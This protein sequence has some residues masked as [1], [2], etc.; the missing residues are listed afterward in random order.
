MPL[1]D[2]LLKILG[3][4]RQADLNQSAIDL[5][6]SINQSQ[7]NQ[8][9][10]QTELEPYSIELQKDS[11]QL[12]IAAGYTGRTIKEIES[13]LNRIE[14]Q[15]V[16]RDWF[17]SQFQDKTPDLVNLLIQHEQNEQKR[18]ET[19]Q[20][21]LGFMHKTAETVPEP[22]RTELF[23]QIRTIEKQIPLTP[24]MN[25]LIEIAKISK[26][27]SYSDL[28]NKLNIGEDALRGLLSNTIKRTN[29]IERFEKLNKGWIRYIGTD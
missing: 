4:K 26:E 27:I 10:V 28:A 7:I 29:I 5:N 25:Q 9:I 6:Q 14:T 3:K 15:M 18:F 23:T 13:S 11:L 12:G 19:I 20:N 16:T 1:K 22:L 17:S 2:L 21:L 24:K 8:S